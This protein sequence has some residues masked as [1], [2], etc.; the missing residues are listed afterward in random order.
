MKII[1][2]FE[3][4]HNREI[5]E[6]FHQL[7]ISNIGHVVYWYDFFKMT[8]SISGD[9]VECG[10]G[11]GRSLLILSALNYLFDKV[12]GGQRD[13]YGYDSFEGFPEP[14]IEDE[15]YRNPKKGEWSHSPSGK[16]KYTVD[17]IERVLF[18][19][20]IPADR[21]FDLKLIKGY[22]DHSLLHH[23]KNPIAILHID[24][25]LYQSYKAVLENLF[26]RVSSGGVIIFDDF[27]SC[28]D[29]KKQRFPGARL[30]VKEFLNEEYDSIKVSNAG[31]YYY[32]KK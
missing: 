5:D 17:F 3:T 7:N 13:I 25:D 2:L 4:A 22:F 15:S 29:E 32:I 11:R 28:E 19:G 24:G 10:V 18:N 1:K 26:D 8:K 9:I 12:E 21:S 30:A 14:T 16:Y 23:P 20:G 6:I 31:T 27:L